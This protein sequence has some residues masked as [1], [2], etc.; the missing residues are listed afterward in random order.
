MYIFY[1]YE[2]RFNH[3]VYTT[4]SIC[5]GKLNSIIFFLRINMC[6]KCICRCCSITKIPKVGS[7]I[8][9]RKINKFNWFTTAHIIYTDIKI[10]FHIRNQHVLSYRILAAFS[11]YYCKFNRKRTHSIISMCCGTATRCTAIMKLPSVSSNRRISGD[12]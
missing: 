12:T 8:C 2:T 10:C 7:G 6:R 11:I 9:R 5:N 1:S 3:C 4:F